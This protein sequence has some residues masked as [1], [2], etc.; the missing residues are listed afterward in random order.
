[1]DFFADNSAAILALAAVVQLVATLGI[2]FFAGVSVWVIREQGKVIKE[3]GDQA[4]QDRQAGMD[5][6]ARINVWGRF[7]D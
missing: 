2:L 4:H 6:I 5:Q 3:Q 1:M 7:A